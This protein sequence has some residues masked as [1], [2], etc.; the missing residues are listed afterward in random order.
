MRHN[1]KIQ[2]PHQA[3]LDAV[4]KQKGFPMIE[5]MAIMII[6]TI[7]SSVFIPHIFDFEKKRAELVVS[8]MWTIAEAV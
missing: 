4:V 7:L 6:I 5:S 2:S 1:L 3:R 8:E